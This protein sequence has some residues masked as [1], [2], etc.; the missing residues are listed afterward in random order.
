[1]VVFCLLLTRGALE[2]RFNGMGPI[3]ILLSLIPGTIEALCS[4]Y[5]G[6][7]FFDMPTKISYTLGFYLA[8]V[9]TISIV[10]NLLNLRR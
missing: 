2:L 1:M 5:L 6:K 10:P 8:S 3:L 9:G 7:F 4:S